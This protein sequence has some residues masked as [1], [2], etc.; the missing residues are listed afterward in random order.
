MKIGLFT[1]SH[2]SSQK[3]TCANRYNS[4]SLRKIEEAYGFF[5]KEKAELVICLGDITDKEDTKEKEIKNLLEIR[6]VIDASK[7]KTIVLMGNHD[8]FTFTEDEFYSHLGEDKRPIDMISENES[9]LFVDACYFADGRRYSPMDDDWTDTFYPFAEKLSEKLSA[10]KGDAFI[11][12]HQNVDGNIREDHR[13]SNDGEMREIFEKSG[14]VKSVFQ[15]HYHKGA[16][17]ETDGIKYITLKAM[18]ENEK[19]YYIIDTE[20]E[21]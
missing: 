20:A 19:A 9:L 2:Y 11:F 12:M 21:G 17:N 8:A 5:K 18:C 10:L 13:L 3:V 16:E 15:G 7:I 6:N 14:K 4:E 1:D